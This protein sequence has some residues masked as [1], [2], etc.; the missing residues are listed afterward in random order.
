MLPR[1]IKSE[2][3]SKYIRKEKCLV[4]RLDTLFSRNMI[5]DKKIFLKFDV[6]GYEMNVLNGAEFIFNNIE[7]IQIEMSLEPLYEGSILYKDMIHFLEMKGFELYSIENGF[8]DPHTGKLLQFDGF[9][10]K[11]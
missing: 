9:F 7:G 8:S 3:N 1:H 2:P 6:Q 11:K 4:N 10:L 5:L